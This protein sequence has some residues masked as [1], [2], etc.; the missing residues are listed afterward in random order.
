[1]R[2]PSPVLSTA[3]TEIPLSALTR[4]IGFFSDMARKVGPGARDPSRPVI[5]FPKDRHFPLTD[6]HTASLLSGVKTNKHLLVGALLVVSTVGLVPLASA[7]PDHRI[8]LSTPAAG[9]TNV[10]TA[11]SFGLGS[12]ASGA[13]ESVRTG[14][15]VYP[16]HDLA[17]PANTFAATVSSS[18]PDG[19]P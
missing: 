13:A 3:W 16:L 12:E 19:E 11:D 7:D 17:E 2:I 15:A 6:H 1:M 9:S 18:V 5:H 4:A 10:R 14:F 8:D